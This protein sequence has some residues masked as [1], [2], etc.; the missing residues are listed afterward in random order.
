MVNLSGACAGLE[1]SRNTPRQE[2]HKRRQVREVVP[3]FF[4]E[5]GKRRPRVAVALWVVV[6]MDGLL[7]LAVGAEHV[8]DLVLVE[9]LHLVA[10]GTQVFAR[11]ELAGLLHEHLAHGGGHGQ[12]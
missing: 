12:A 8:D 10:G 6:C 7:G 3:S 5:V 11:V 9:A 2:K 1:G 4:C